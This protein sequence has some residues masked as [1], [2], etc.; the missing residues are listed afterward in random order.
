MST[1]ESCV[2][3][4]RWRYLWNSRSYRAKGQILGSK[5]RFELF[6]LV[7]EEKK[8]YGASVRTVIGVPLADFLVKR[9][10]Q[11]MFMG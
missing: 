11:E 5:H 7:K 2:A 8:I 6:W 3:W 1:L 10:R 4:V 9:P